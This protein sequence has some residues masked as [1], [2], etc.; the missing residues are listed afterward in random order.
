MPD[1]IDWT[2]LINKIYP[3]G[4]IY[5]SYNNTSPQSFIGGT[6]VKIEGRFLLAA[7]G[8]YTAGA[9]GGA[10]THTLTLDQ[11]PPHSHVSNWIASTPGQELG[12]GGI[13]GVHSDS[14]V[15]GAAG[16]GQ[17]HNNMPPYLVVHMWRR[18]A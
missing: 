13:N 11:I 3:V 5:M 9:T 15:T 12:F 8:G 4:S 1:K 17:A 7:G 10:A 16:G 6:W 14:L 2:T 18:T